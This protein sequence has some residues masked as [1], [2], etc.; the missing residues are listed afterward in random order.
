MKRCTQCG[1]NRFKTSY[2]DRP[3]SPRLP[4][5]ML[6]GIL[7]DTC[8][9]CGEYEIE[10]P[11]HLELT[12]AVTTAILNKKALLA[13]G[14]IR[15]LRSCLGFT[16]EE[17]AKNLGVSR[18]V[19]S[20]WENGHRLQDPTSDRLLRLA[21]APTLPAGSFSLS[22]A[23]QI[24]AEKREPLTLSLRFEESRGWQIVEPYTKEQFVQIPTNDPLHPGW[25]TWLQPLG[26]QTNPF[27]EESKG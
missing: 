19:V 9:K 7:K 12:N 1:E 18:T 6:I 24:T 21:V 14:E 22:T 13:A 15:W 26:V 27:A 3:V 20:Y 25:E 11:K 4:Q 23:S 2:E 8:L 5:M 16:G 10:I 17:L